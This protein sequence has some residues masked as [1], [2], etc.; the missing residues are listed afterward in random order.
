MRVQIPITE[1][2]TSNNQTE[3]LLHISSTYVWIQNIT[4]DYQF[5]EIKITKVKRLSR[6][7]RQLWSYRPI[8]VKEF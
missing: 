4:L 6:I 5:V 1:A 2:S 3:I 8:I 7:T